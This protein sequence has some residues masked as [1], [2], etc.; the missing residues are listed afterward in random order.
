MRDAFVLE[1]ELN[2]GFACCRCQYVKM[3]QGDNSIWESFPRVLESWSGARRYITAF[4]V[5]PESTA[6]TCAEGMFPAWD[7]TSTSW[8]WAIAWGSP[9]GPLRDQFLSL[10]R[11]GARRGGRF[12]GTA[13]GSAQLPFPRGDQPAAPSGGSDPGGILPSLLP[14]RSLLQVLKS[15][16]TAGCSINDSWS[17][18]GARSPG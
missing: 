15:G 14:P 11:A 12:A 10:G 17:L 7:P 5:S 2:F 3:M 1:G 8:K 13:T 18:P 16:P 9:R 4:R 6:G